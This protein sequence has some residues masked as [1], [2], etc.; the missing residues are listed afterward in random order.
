VVTGLEL[1]FLGL[2][3]LTATCGGMIYR[4]FEANV[5]MLT[6]AG[7]LLLLVALWAVRAVLLAPNRQAL[8]RQT[9]ALAG[10]VT[11]AI[12]VHVADGAYVHLRSRA[13]E[14]DWAGPLPRSEFPLATKEL[15]YPGAN[16]ILLSIDTLRA[17]HLGCYGYRGDTSPHLDAFARE[18]VR[19]ART[20]APSSTTLPSHASLLTSLYPGTHKAEVERSIP[21][22][23]GVTTL[24][25]VLAGAG[26][27]T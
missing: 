27:R 7:W 11:A 6:P 10:V 8:R 18:G 19:F 25:E 14:V 13:P 24:A 5:L 21:L 22:A 3:L 16:V 12:L 9:K 17:D 1:L 26:Y 20:Y 15:T 2:A 23:P 4:F